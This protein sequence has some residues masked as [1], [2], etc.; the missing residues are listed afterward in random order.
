VLWYGGEASVEEMLEAEVV[1]THDEVP[2][3]EVSP[4]MSYGLNEADELPFIGRQFSV[5]G[6]DLAAEEG[7]GSRSWWST[8]PKPEPDASQS[9]MK[10]WSKLGSCNTGAVVSAVLRASNA[11]VAAAVQWN[12]SFLRRAVN[13]AAMRP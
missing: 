9:T 10:G 6:G 2:C 13:G 12:A 4:P 1:R 11:S 7:D 8:T 3:P 5:L